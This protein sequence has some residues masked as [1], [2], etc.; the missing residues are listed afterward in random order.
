MFK[1]LQINA[2]LI[3]LKMKGMPIL[4]KKNEGSSNEDKL[5]IILPW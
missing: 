3:A 5:V 2:I 4:R 1:W